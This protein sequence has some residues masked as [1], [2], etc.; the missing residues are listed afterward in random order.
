M[1]MLLS[2]VFALLPQA[3]LAG[4]QSLLDGYVPG[5]YVYYLDNRQAQPRLIGLLKV[6]DDQ[7]LCRG[8]DIAGKRS[9]S[10][11]L[12]ISRKNGETEL[13]P[14]GAKADDGNI[15]AATF[16]TTDLMN[17]AAQFDKVKW[18]KPFQEI[19]L[20]DEWPEFGYTLIHTYKSW[21]PFFQL[22][23]TRKKDLAEPG[24][25][26]I[27]MSR[28]DPSQPDITKD[29]FFN[30]DVIP[31]AAKR[32]GF[33]L[34]KAAAMEVT[35]ERATFML[36][37]NWVFFEALPEKGLPY[38]SYWIRQ[39]SARD[40]IV[41]VEKVPVKNAK[42]AIDRLA[43][44]FVQ[45]NPNPVVVSSVRYEKMDNQVIIRFVTLDKETFAETQHF[46]RL[47]LVAKD[48]IQVINFSSYKAVYDANKEYF[49][50]VLGSITVK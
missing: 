21:L 12:E 19:S 10:I 43:K 3:L 29:L 7:M 15:N 31:E 11:V 28:V 49:D 17:M 44:L 48:E 16:L 9:Y 34:P 41:S 32:K 13:K 18:Q 47:A 35:L 33:I 22:A 4:T 46:Q 37:K 25:T 27:I 39:N 36:D 50:A 42:G 26:A 8:Y 2:I 40:A 30:L 20:A 6:S 45:A 38:A 23:A 5:Q 24:Y 14:K 1:R